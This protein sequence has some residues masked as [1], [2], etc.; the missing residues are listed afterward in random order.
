MG[1]GSQI[2]WAINAEHFP[3]AREQQFY[4]SHID[5]TG[6]GDLG[7]HIKKIRRKKG[8]RSEEKP[9]PGLAWHFPNDFSW[10]KP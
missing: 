3:N 9:E 7:I 8:K 6:T 10:N 2:F 5:L 1:R 4:Y